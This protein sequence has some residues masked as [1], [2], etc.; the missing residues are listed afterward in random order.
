MGR[1]VY[2]NKIAFGRSAFIPTQSATESAVYTQLESS[3]SEIPQRYWE[4]TANN[5][6]QLYDER[7]NPINPRAREYGKKLRSA[8][9]D[10]LA[11]VGVV[12]RRAAPEDGLPGS[13]QE[14]MELL[15]D[16]DGIGH[17]LSLTSKFTEEMCTWWIRSI[18]AR[19]MV[20]YLYTSSYAVLKP[21]RPF[22][23]P[24]GFLSA[25]S[26][27]ASWPHAA[28]L[29]LTQAFLLNYALS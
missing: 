23:T 14:R 15:E 10:V 26:L 3:Q 13:Y 27:L 29:L 7:G 5:Y 9:N 25:K 6:L 20:C 4:A 11:S 18:R 22:A 8:Q 1:E 28:P 16:E 2:L 21:G 19:V 12:Q 24:L 17:F